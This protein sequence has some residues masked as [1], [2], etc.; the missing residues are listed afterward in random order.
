MAIF[1]PVLNK[2]E[3][4]KLIENMFYVQIKVNHNLIAMRSNSQ[5]ESNLVIMNYDLE[6]VNQI[7]VGILRG[8]DD[9]FIYA[10]DK[11]ENEEYSTDIK[12]ID[13]SLETVKTLQF[14]CTNSMDPFFYDIQYSFIFKRGYVSFK[15]FE[16]IFFL[17]YMNTVSLYSENGSL[18]KDLLCR[19]ENSLKFHN[20][21]IVCV[22]NYENKLSYYDSKTDLAIKEIN[23]I[24]IN[25]NTMDR[26]YQIKFDSDDKIFLYDFKFNCLRLC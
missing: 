20:K 22:D 16:N 13:W 19:I 8:A 24:N 25:L 5:N 17:K 23:L 14:Q 15:I 21:N 4:E 2:L 6:M 26:Q 11:L 9:S 18:I 7:P 1:D 12:V 3:K 10:S